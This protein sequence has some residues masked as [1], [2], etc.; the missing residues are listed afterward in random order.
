MQ[1]LCK[2]A[3]VAFLD[4]LRLACLMLSQWYLLNDGR[5]PDIN[6]EKLRELD[7]RDEYYPWIDKLIEKKSSSVRQGLL[8]V[9]FTNHN[10]FILGKH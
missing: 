6:L 2:S 3:I 10:F 4:F 5:V 1:Q 8:P 7:V 9:F